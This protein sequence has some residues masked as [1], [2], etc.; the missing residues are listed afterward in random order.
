MLG[1]SVQP[2]NF[3]LARESIPFGFPGVQRRSMRR[4]LWR[5]MEQMWFGP[6]FIVILYEDVG[7]SVLV[8]GEIMDW[9][10]IGKAAKQGDSIAP[11]LFVIV[12]DFLIWSINKNP[13]IKG[14]VDPLGKEIKLSVLA[15]DNLLMLDTDEETLEEAQEEVR[16]HGELSGLEINWEK[17]VVLLL[18][19]PGSVPDCLAHMKILGE[20][21]KHKHLGIPLML[22]VSEH[23]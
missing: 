12:E 23:T 4:F 2:S 18:N 7:A 17:T 8:N 9:F 21:E 3:L 10:G 15:D 13:R 6:N 19:Y 11:F 22:E 14:I 20:G 5:G 16:G 1:I